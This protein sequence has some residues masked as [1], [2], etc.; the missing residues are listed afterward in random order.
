MIECIKYIPVNK[1]TCLGFVTIYVDKWDM[2][3]SSIA[4]HQKDGK[5]WISFPY[6]E[7]EKDGVKKYSPYFR[8]SK[9]ANYKLFTEAVKAAIDKHAL[10]HAE[11]PKVE[12][13]P[14]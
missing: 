7:Y 1:N 10:T 13:Q 2:E 11:Q 5:R 6:K 3:I 14:F 8:F 9:P 4:L 12:E